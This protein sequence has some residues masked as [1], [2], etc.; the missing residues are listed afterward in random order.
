MR[1][2][3]FRGYPTDILEKSI[4][5]S[6]IILDENLGMSIRRKSLAKLWRISSSSSNYTYKINNMRYYGLTNATKHSDQIELTQLSRE[7]LEPGSKDQLSRVLQEAASIPPKF[8]DFYKLLE[9][10]KIP[11]DNNLKR[12]IALNIS[13]NK[14]LIDEYINIAVQNGIFSGLISKGDESMFVERFSSSLKS[15]DDTEYDSGSSSHA[16]DR[17]DMS[18]DALENNNITRFEPKIISSNKYESI[19][20]KYFTETETISVIRNMFELMDLE[21]KDL[22]VSISDSIPNNENEYSVFIID[23]DKDLKD[24]QFWMQLGSFITLLNENCL[25][26]SSYNDS[27]PIPEMHKHRI[28]QLNSIDKHQIQF[29]LIEHLIQNN[30]ININLS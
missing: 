28:L 5:D 1:K 21:Y 11:H 12:I 19:S 24:I 9:D 10:K 14:E 4:L 27:T 17:Y 13:I 16:I 3:N 18:E 20:L 7:I 30:I 23:S 2:R 6:K 15:S 8:A 29:E 25:F 22:L 26:I